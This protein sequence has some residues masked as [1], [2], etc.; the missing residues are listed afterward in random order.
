MFSLENR[1][2]VKAIR[3][4]FYI[5]LEVLIFLMTRYTWKRI[6]LLLQW[7]QWLPIAAVIKLLVLIMLGLA[8]G[9]LVIGPLFLDTDPPLIT[10]LS[11]RSLGVVIF[12]A[13]SLVTV[14]VCSYIVRKLFCKSFNKDKDLRIRTIFALC[15]TFVLLCT[16]VIGLTRFTI[17]RVRIPVKGL[18]SR[19]NGTTIL[20]MSDIH[21]GPFNGRTQ[22][23]KLLESVNKLDADIVVITGDLVDSSVVSLRET[24]KPLV[25]IKSKYGV[26]FS[27]GEYLFPPLATIIATPSCLAPRLATRNYIVN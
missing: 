17:E 12:L 25:T 6:A 7:T 20:Q 16:G 22:L 26:Y 13:A 8:Q 10:V 23:V 15:F 5:I 27:T 24:V 14:D 2:R 19:L 4:H 3:M 18:D 9:A 11:N 21:L 1:A